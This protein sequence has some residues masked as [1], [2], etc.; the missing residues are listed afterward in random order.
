MDI[1]VVSDVTF[2]TTLFAS[3]GCSEDQ[4]KVRQESIF[5]FKVLSK[6][7]AAIL[8]ELMETNEGKLAYVCLFVSNEAQGILQQ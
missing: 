6:Q 2:L 8:S 7:E 1:W 4:I 5:Y 3:Q